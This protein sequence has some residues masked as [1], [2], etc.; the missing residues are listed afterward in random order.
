MS[1]AAFYILANKRNGTLYCGS[2]DDLARRVWEH[3]NGIKAKFTTKYKVYLLVYY[4]HY[5]LLMDARSR[6]YKIKKWRRVWKL[7][8]IEEM[9]PQWR[10]LYLDL[11]S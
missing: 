2:T 7:A 11:N 1:D 8:L 5:D 9:N 3:R 6:E 10:D 4:E